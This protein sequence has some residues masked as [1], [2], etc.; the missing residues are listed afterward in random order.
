MLPL[1]ARADA[2]PAPP[3]GSPLPDE[4]VLGAFVITGVNAGQAPLPKIAV[5]PSLSPVYE[6][7]IVRG[8]V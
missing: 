3:A 8:V 4:G 1:T 2:P 7:V 6:D 5:L